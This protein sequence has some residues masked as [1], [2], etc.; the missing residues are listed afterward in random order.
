MSL[1]LRALG[2]ILTAALAAAL[3]T[4]AWPPPPGAGSGGP[5]GRARVVRVID[6]DTAVVDLGGGDT[7]VRFIGIDTPETVAP[8][9][10]VECFGPEASS[11]LKQLL[12]PGTAVRLWRDV[13]PLDRYDRLLA[14]VQRSSDGLF[15]NVAQV[16]DGYA[17]AKSYPPNTWYRTTFEAAEAAARAGGVG[18][19]STCG[20]ADVVLGPAPA[21]PATRAPP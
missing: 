15:V 4:M 3:T 5:P 18:L 19:W 16:A 20:G 21:G 1:V 2:A 12:P 9:R 13:E 10:P 8:D 17:I 6:G 11:R 7:T 14:Y